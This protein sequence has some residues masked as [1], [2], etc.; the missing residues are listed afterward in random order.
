MAAKVKFPEKPQVQP[1]A[2]KPCGGAGEGEML[3]ASLAAS[4]P[5]GSWGEQVS[6]AGLKHPWFS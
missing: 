4:W 6:S 2:W 5:Q 3:P 1:R